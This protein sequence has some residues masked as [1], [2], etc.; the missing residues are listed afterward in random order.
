L[1]GT[2]KKRARVSPKCVGAALLISALWLVGCSGASGSYVWVWDL[3]PAAKTVEPLRPGDRVQVAVQGQEAMSGEFEIRPEGD[4]VLPTAGRF[5]AAGWPP[6][7]LAGVVQT[8][9]RGVLQDPRVTI[10]VAAR[11]TP[12]VGV[13][14][15][16][17][18]PGRYEMRIGEGV[19]DALAR[20]GGITPFADPNLV[21]VIRKVAGKQ[22]QRV[23]FRYS[24]LVAADPA[25]V[26][27][28]LRDG[29]VLVV[30]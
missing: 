7:Q 12:Q 23:R 10:V 30:E 13:L 20:A 5:Q 18:S 1:E 2:V 3:P 8:R 22:V 9:L 29:D 15:E 27:F 14:G 16:V 11:R 25:S 24:E 28:E 19:L 21:F 4:V 17:R 6:D 26:A